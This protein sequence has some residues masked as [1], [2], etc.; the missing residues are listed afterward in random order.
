MELTEVQGIR[1]S[2]LDIQTPTTNISQAIAIIAALLILSAMTIYAA[3]RSHIAAEDIGAL[4]V[5]FEGAWRLVST[6]TKK[7]VRPPHSHPSSLP[8]AY[9][10]TIL[11]TPPVCRGIGRYQRCPGRVLRRPCD[12][13]NWG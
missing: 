2:E 7:I 6:S 13:P 10:S 4:A 9:A 8:N 11:L 5:P 3:L 1:V 12:R